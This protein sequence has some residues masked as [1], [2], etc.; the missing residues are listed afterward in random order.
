[1]GQIRRRLGGTAEPV[2]RSHSA[3][4]CGWRVAGAWGRGARVDGAA[5]AESAGEGTAQHVSAEACAPGRPGSL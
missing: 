2:T 3:L 5:E 1:M 4:G